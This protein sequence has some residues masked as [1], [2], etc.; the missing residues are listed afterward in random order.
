MPKI[1]D[2]KTRA[3][4]VEFAKEKNNQHEAAR[5]FGVS[6]MYVNAAVN[7]RPIKRTRSSRFVCPITGLKI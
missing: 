1:I 4:I 6:F 5:V 7:N 2:K 3:A